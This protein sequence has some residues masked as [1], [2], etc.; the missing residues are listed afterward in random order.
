MFLYLLDE[1]DR[2]ILKTASRKFWHVFRAHRFGRCLLG[3]FTI[4]ITAPWSL[5]TANNEVSQRGGRAGR[6]G[7]I[8]EGFV[9]PYPWILK[10]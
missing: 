9:M 2:F 4:L 5:A 8:V 10:G 7:E 3:L 6:R 1:I